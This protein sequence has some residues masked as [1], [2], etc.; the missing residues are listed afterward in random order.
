VRRL[1]TVMVLALLAGGC[2]GA[3]PGGSSTW[4]TSP[5]PPTTSPTSS[6]GS[7]PLT[8]AQAGSR[9]LEIVRPYNTALEKFEDAAHA[10]TPW[11]NLRPLA[12][13]VAQANAAHAKALR[14]TSWPAAVRAPM[15]ALL[16]EIDLAQRSWQRAAQAKTADEL[17]RAVRA[18]AA[19]SGSK[20]AGQIR[21]LLGLPPYSE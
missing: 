5:A 21:T 17:A 16:T 18:A 12:G 14:Q 10:G 15:A 2:E 13:R 1:V 19:H 6:A 3:G 8:V 11:K 20:P 4:V 9:Y 7:T